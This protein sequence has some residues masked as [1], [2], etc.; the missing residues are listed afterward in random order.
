MPP[1]VETLNRPDK[2]PLEATFSDISAVPFSVGGPPVYLIH[3]AGQVGTPSLGSA[4]EI[5]TSFKEQARNAFQNVAACLA[6]KGATPQ[7]IIKITIYVVNYDPSLRG[8]II[9]VI[10]SFFTAIDGHRHE[11][12]STLLGV[13]SLALPEF[14]IEVDATAVIRS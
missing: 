14:L 6:L 4:Q 11:P 2:Q 13:A 7:D 1:F 5:P 10:S 8:E 12:P 9:D 3:T